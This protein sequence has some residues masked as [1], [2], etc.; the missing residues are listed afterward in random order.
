MRKTLL[1]LVLLIAGY[2]QAQTYNFELRQD[3][4]NQYLFTLYAHPSAS[5]T[6]LAFDQINFDIFLPSGGPYSV[7][8]LTNLLSLDG[9]SQPANWALQQTFTGAV[10]GPGG[11]NIDDGSRD[12]LVIGIPV[13]NYVITHGTTEFAVMSFE[14]TGNPTSGSIEL[15]ANNDPVK[16]A[17]KGFGQ[18]VDNTF[19]VGGSNSF[20]ATTGTTTYGFAPLSNPEVELTGV[21]MFPNPANDFIRISAEN[22]E[23]KDITFF[24]INGSRVKTVASNFEQV[25]VKALSAGVYFVKVSSEDASTTIKLVKK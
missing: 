20:G 4:S 12:F 6:G 18:N 5:A 1:L 16:V 23:I 8:N 9:G 19:L 25:D 15:I 2:A 22:A 3:M 14:V 11:A 21:S 24:N 7:T 10:L 13:N 17:L